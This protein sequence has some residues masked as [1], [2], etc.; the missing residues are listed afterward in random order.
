[1]S[2]YRFRSAMVLLAIA[3]G[4]AAVISLTALGEGARRYVLGEFEFL[5]KDTLVM[6]PGKTETTGALPPITGGAARDITLDDVHFLERRLSSIAEMAPLVV[7]SAEVSYLQRAREVTIIGSSSAFVSIRQ[8]GLARGRNIRTDDI[9]RAG[10]E[11]LIGETLKSELLGDTNAIGTLLRVADYRCRVVGILAGKGDAFGMDLSD[12]LII[13]VASAQRLFNVS[14]LLRLLIKIHPNYTLPAAKAQIIAVMKNLH[15][16]EEDVTVISPDAMLA[17]FDDILSA[18]TMGVAAIGA[19]SLVV[20]GILIMNI[21]LISVSQRTEEIGLLKALG[22]SSRQ[23]QYLF[24]SESLMMSSLGALLGFTLGQGLIVL[25]R[26]A[27]PD[28]AFSAPLWAVIAAFAVS[29]LSGLIFAWF[30]TK[31]ASALAPLAALQKR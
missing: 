20:A 11:C 2:R 15:Q 19:I 24:L 27:M 21:T 18:M 8:M 12:A 29:I 16:N 26:I 3:L 28:V 1:M 4:V 25:G 22:A 7:G 6:F 13:P 17:T 31:T 10:E 30:P 14:G 23:V 9:R 5:G